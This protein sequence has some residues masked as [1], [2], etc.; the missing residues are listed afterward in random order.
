MT[1]ESEVANLTTA[2]NALTNTVNVKKVTLDV[3]TDSAASSATIAT[4]KA[5]EASASA[6]SALASKNAAEAAEAAAVAIV[7]G[8]EYS[9]TAAAGKVPIADVDGNIGNDWLDI[10]SAPQE[11]P[12][13]A[14][15][16]GMAYQSPESVVIK[17]QASAAPTGIGEAVFQL[18]SDTS[19]EIKVKGSDGTVRSV[20]L[21]LA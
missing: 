20:A 2:V 14:H 7:Y 13:N 17:P 16:G 19:L 18:T 1:V 5:S 12:T 9:T 4:T 3:A 10:G 15:L 6:A 8:G 21:T 11:I